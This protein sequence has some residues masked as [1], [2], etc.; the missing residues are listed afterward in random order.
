MLEIGKSRQFQSN[1]Y[2]VEFLID[3]TLKLCLK[4]HFDQN[5]FQEFER[6]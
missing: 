4:Q 5:M 3:L 2:C 1:D 6:V